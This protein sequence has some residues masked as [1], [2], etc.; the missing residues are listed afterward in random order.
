MVA[1][2][3]VDQAFKLGRL[4]RCVVIGFDVLHFRIFCLVVVRS[5]VGRRLGELSTSGQAFFS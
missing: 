4:G 5:D 1:R 2:G 3:Y